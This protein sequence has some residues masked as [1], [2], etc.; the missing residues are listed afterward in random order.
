LQKNKNVGLLKTASF[1]KLNNY[2]L[3]TDILIFP[4]EPVNVAEDEGVDGFTGVP[5]G[6][7]L[8]P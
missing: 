1:G 3:F 6:L 7:S 4:F 8:C 5:W 2:L